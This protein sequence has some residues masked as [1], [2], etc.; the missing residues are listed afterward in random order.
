MQLVSVGEFGNVPKKLQYFGID[1]NSQDSS[2]LI[3]IG[4]IEDG[5]KT[6]NLW[7]V[8]IQNDSL[9]TPVRKRR[10]KGIPVCTSDETVVP[11]QRSPVVPSVRFFE[12]LKLEEARR[13]ASTNQAA[14]LAAQ[15]REEQW[16]MEEERKRLEEAR[17][18][19]TQL[20]RNES[21]RLRN[22]KE[23]IARRRKTSESRR[24]LITRLE[25][26][27]EDAK[28]EIDM[29]TELA[30]AMREETRCAIASTTKRLERVRL[31]MEK[32]SVLRPLEEADILDD[33]VLEDQ[34]RKRDFPTGNPVIAEMKFRY[35][36]PGESEDDGDDHDV[37]P[38]LVPITQPKAAII[39]S[40]SAAAVG[41]FNYLR[42][43]E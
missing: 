38:N 34:V 11:K 4:G 7:S 8:K 22:I 24:Q 23:A 20:L 25:A 5:I 18:E 43:G 15:R 36:F 9:S 3:L 17:A 41:Y 12:E 33:P 27:I 10:A 37:V 31:V 13:E 14:V 40:A 26:E 2:E 6:N 28:E 42:R 21:E 39:G 29:H 1:V 35:R 32:T 16:R 30:R 19:E